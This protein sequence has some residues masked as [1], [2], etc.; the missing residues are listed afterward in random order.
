MINVMTHFSNKYVN[1]PFISSNIPAYI[2]YISYLIRYSRVCGQYSNSLDKAHLL[3]QKLLKQGY[4]VSRLR[5]SLQRFY[6]ISSSRTGWLLRNIFTG[7]VYPSRTFRLTPWFYCGSVFWHLFSL[8]CYVGL[9]S[10]VSA[11]CCMCLCILHFWMRLLFS[12][13]FLCQIFFLNFFVC[14][15]QM[16]KDY[17]DSLY[18]HSDKS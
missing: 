1:F 17:F 4:V 14:T 16:I 10:V 13:V 11:P 2:A 8:M 5:S 9:R 7:T 6:E 12:H 3:T 15:I 18:I